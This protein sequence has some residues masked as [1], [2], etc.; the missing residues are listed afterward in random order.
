MSLFKD[1]M[2]HFG[3]DEPMGEWEQNVISNLL[4]IYGDGMISKKDT[5]TSHR[6][7]SRE[8]ELC[9]SVS[10]ELAANCTSELGMGS[11][12]SDNFKPFYMTAQ[13]GTS[14]TNDVPT[15]ITAELI[16]TKFADTIFPFTKVVV[17]PLVPEGKWWDSATGGSDED[18]DYV[19]SWKNMIELFTE[20]P[21]LHS[22]VF[23]QIGFYEGNDYSEEEGCPPGFLS[24]GYILP[25]MPLA[26][27]S[28]GSIVGLFGTV[29]N[30]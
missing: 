27:T 11:E 8:L 19:V 28:R 24:E 17:E 14:D 9:K 13:M 29:T 10:Q 12:A 16:R 21:D 26:L 23:V 18:S 25:R 20:H 15:E 1:C 3:A 7:S 30:T 4:V 5:P 2:D 6:V 22:P